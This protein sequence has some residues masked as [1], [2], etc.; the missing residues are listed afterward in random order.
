MLANPFSDRS[1]RL[2]LAVIH[3][4]R[5][6][7]NFD[8]RYSRLSNFRQQYGSQRLGRVSVGGE[9]ALHGLEVVCFRGPQH[10]AANSAR[11][12]AVR[13]P[14]MVCGK[15]ARVNTRVPRPVDGGQAPPTARPSWDRS[16]LPLLRRSTRAAPP[17]DTRAAPNRSRLHPE[18]A[19]QSAQHP[20]STVDENAA[21]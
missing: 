11:L 8:L 14:S 18:T 10:S 2:N 9:D 7:V 13:R 15:L 6:A 5:R 4:H 19:V 3:V 20:A 16:Q 21:R 12:T 1:N 17:D